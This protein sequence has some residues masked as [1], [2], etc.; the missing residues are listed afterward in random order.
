MDENLD[1]YMTA[2]QLFDWAKTSMNIIKL[3]SDMSEGDICRAIRWIGMC[4][5]DTIYIDCDKPKLRRL[6]IGL[7]LS[8]TL[9]AFPNLYVKYAL[10]QQ[11]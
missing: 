6:G 1:E 8:V 11:N 7:I 9:M 5:I 4:A 2:D 10:A 3:N